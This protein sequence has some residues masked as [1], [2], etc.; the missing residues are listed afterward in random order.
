[1]TNEHN[2]L[3]VELGRGGQLYAFYEIFNRR[4][5]RLEKAA[6]AESIILMRS[7]MSRSFLT[8]TS[9]SM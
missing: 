8:L 1:M 9:I 5:F 4:V 3:M 6:E 2:P 7:P